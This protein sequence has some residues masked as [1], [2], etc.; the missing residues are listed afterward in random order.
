VTTR[1]ELL[2]AGAAGWAAAA[3]GRPAAAGAV[4]GESSAMFALIALEDAAAAAYDRAAVTTRHPLLARIAAQDVEHG[5]A[6]RVGLEALTV[7]PAH[8]TEGA[9]LSDPA[10]SV[11]A[12]AADRR[13]ALD[14]AI[15]FEEQVERA[16]AAAAAELVTG[17]LLQTA[18]SIFGSHAQQ[19][20]ALRTA[21]GLPPLGEP[22]VSAA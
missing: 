13:E 4:A 7:V 14:A 15:A 8:H 11:L 2:A 17:G 19:L 5:N 12:S 20:A 9:E 3:L 22:L 6:L 10:A 1:R 16:Y 18:A 21:A